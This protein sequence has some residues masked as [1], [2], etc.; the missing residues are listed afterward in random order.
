MHHQDNI[1]DDEEV[2][3]VPEDFIVERPVTKNISVFHTVLPS[4]VLLYELST[5]YK[6]AEGDSGNSFM[7]LK[8]GMEKRTNLAN[9]H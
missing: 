4:P 2:V 9:P 5:S 8:F 7:F 3:C 1:E 6:V